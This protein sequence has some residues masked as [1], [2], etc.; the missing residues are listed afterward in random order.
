MP[1]LRGFLGGAYFVGDHVFN[2]TIRYIDGYDNDQSGNNPVD[3][4][5]TLDLMYSYTFAGL[6]GDGDTSITVGVNNV[7]DE[8]PPALNRGVPRVDPV[9]GIYNR[10][11][12]DRPGYDDRAG[13]SLIGTEYYIRFKHAF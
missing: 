5:T 4:W 3:S 13:H 10:G 2:G 9:T 1:Q 7:T 12:I 8:D 6:I 11:W